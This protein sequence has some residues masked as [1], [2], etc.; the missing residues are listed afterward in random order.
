MLTREDAAHRT[1]QRSLDR[2]RRAEGELGHAMDDLIGGIEAMREIG[3]VVDVVM[4]P[5]T[6]AAWVEH[7]AMRRPAE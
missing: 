2:F 6:S 5:S 1:F 3:T 4:K 7:R